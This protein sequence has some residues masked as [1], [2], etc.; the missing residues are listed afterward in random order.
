MSRAPT[1]ESQGTY[2]EE[3]QRSSLR[4]QGL[5]RRGKSWSGHERNCCF[6]NIGGKSFANISAVSG[7]NFLDD[8]RAVASVDWDHDGDL[9]LWNTNRTSPGVRFLR[10]DFPTDHHYLALK[11][12]GNGTTCNRDAIGARVELYPGKIIKTL[13]AGEGFL[14]QSTKWIHFGMGQNRQVDRVVVRWPDGTSQEFTHMEADQRYEIIQ[15]SVRPTPWIAPSRDVALKPSVLPVLPVSDRTR[16]LLPARL[17]MPPLT[18]NLASSYGSGKAIAGQPFL[19]NLWASWCQPCVKELRQF[20]QRADELKD[21]KVQIF[22]MSVDGLGDDSSNPQNAQALLKQLKFPFMHGVATTALLDKLQIVKESLFFPIRPLPLPS[23]FLVDPQGRLAVIYHGPVG[24]DELIADVR[25]LKLDEDDWRQASVPFQGRYLGPQVGHDLLAILDRLREHEHVEAAL[26]YS[27]RNSALMGYDRPRYASITYKIGAEFTR[28]KMHDKAAA[29]YHEVIHASPEHLNARRAMAAALESVGRFKEAITHYRWLVQS[30]PENARARLKLSALLARHGNK[31]AAVKDLRQ[32]LQSN[33]ESSQTHYLLATVLEKEKR[34]EEAIT[35]YQ[36][37]LGLDP[38]LA[39]AH[40]RIGSAFQ[41]QG[42][43]VPA[44]KHWRSLVQLRPK[45]AAAHLRLGENLYRQEMIETSLQAFR[46]ALELDPE[47][48]IAQNYAAWILCTFPEE[49]LRDGDQALRWAQSS[50]RA[51]DHQN[52]GVLDTLAAAYAEVGRFE[53][54]VTTAQKAI[55]L[56]LA[57]HLKKQ[58]KQTQGR[59]EL[60]KKGRPCRVN[61]DGQ[62]YPAN[63]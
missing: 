56:A 2:S 13:R 58:A 43:L 3:F 7:F 57:S 24:V 46:V 20:V 28:R 40:A 18:L 52:G 5:L 35:H 50:A 63:K 19:L 62:P 59:L 27:Q 51:T 42:Q 25:R 1:L 44:E 38:S 54:A 41:R 37:A 60:Y 14:A 48:P 53:D 30:N 21:A 26:E 39:L 23:S 16:T 32:A 6:L 34:V 22:A 45:S 8:A 61:K 36:A 47:N 10:N 49:R 29:A 33:P 31:P 9:D 55:E 4:A 15:G 12:T 11:L 17:V